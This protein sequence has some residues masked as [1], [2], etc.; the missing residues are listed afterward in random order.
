MASFV[1]TD[2]RVEINAVNLSPRVKGVTIS[3]SKE[4]VE[5]TAMGDTGRRRKAGLADWSADI[6]FYD[7]EAASQTMATLF[8]IVGTEVALKVRATSA[9]VSATNPEY[10]G[11][12]MIESLPVLAGDVGAMA[13]TAIRMVGS[14]GV[15][16]TRNTV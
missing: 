15:A 14:D 4:I 3:Y 13:M 7:D 9:A 2:A 16:M 11:S 6:E 1:L 8:G 10:R 5:A 12:G